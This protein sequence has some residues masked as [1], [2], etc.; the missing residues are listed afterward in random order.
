MS[1]HPFERPAAKRSVTGNGR[2]GNLVL[3]LLMLLEREAM[4]FRNQD[5]EPFADMI[6]GKR[7]ETWPIESIGFSQLAIRRC[8]EAL[9]RVP[10]RE[11]LAL[12]VAALAA[13]AAIEGSRRV[14]LRV[15]KADG[16]LYLDL[17]DHDCRVI[18]ISPEGWRLVTHPPV[19]FARS[20]KMQ[21]LP[22]PQ[23]GASIDIC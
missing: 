17:A 8:R 4:L 14:D 15:A 19:R 7:L 12:V 21:A 11:T 23:A 2:R 9:G 18:E 16:K 6:V 3:Q 13:S 5:G 10:S 22:V 20:L 1:F